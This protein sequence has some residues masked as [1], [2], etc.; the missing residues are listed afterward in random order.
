ME[1]PRSDIKAEGMMYN[2]KVKSS[3]AGSESNTMDSFQD[4][5]QQNMN[6]D[7]SQSDYV[8]PMDGPRANS[9]HNNYP[10]DSEEQSSGRTEYGKVNDNIPTS[11]YNSGFNRGNFGMGDQHGGLP[12][13]SS[14]EF[15]QQNSSFSQYGQP[16]MRSGYPQPSRQG[17]MPPRGGMTGG[18]MNMMPP[19]FNSGQPRMMSGP[20]IQQQQS[21]P[22]PTLNQLLQNASSQRYPGGYGDYGMGQQKG[23]NDVANSPG[24]NQSGSW[25]QPRPGGGYPPMPGNQ[26]FRSQVQYSMLWWMLFECIFIL[27]CDIIS[28]Y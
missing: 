3:N 5:G 10:H 23:M 4:G 16:N 27:F 22:T 9:E 26:P 11:Q 8:P 12:S 13:S 17:P 25:G 7:R 21:G 24:F 1:N 2:A 19:N 15:P 18:G 20:S 14:G 6:L 28:M